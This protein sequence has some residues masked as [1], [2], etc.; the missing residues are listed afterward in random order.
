[1]DVPAIVIVT[2]DVQDLLA[3]DAQHAGET[4]LANRCTREERRRVVAYPERMHS[5]KP[6][7]KVR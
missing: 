1:M 5:V 6:R 4:V 2:V 3:L 7:S